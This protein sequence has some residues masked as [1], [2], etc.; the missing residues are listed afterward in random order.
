[1]FVTSG[2]I[3]RTRVWRTVLATTVAQ[4]DFVDI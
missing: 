1:M 4:I 2:D 3:R